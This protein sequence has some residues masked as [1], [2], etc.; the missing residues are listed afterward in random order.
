[1]NSKIFLMSSA[2][3]FQEELLSPFSRAMADEGGG[4]RPERQ[5]RVGSTGRG[6][7]RVPESRGGRAAMLGP[8][9]GGDF[10][11]RQSFLFGSFLFHSRRRCSRS[12]P[13][14]SFCWSRAQT[15]CRRR[16]PAPLPPLPASLSATFLPP[17][18][19][20]LRPP[21]SLPSR[22]SSSSS[23]PLGLPALRVRPGRLSAS[24]AAAF[25]DVLLPGAPCPQCGGAAFG[26]PAPLPA[27]AR[28][29]EP[30][31]G[32]CGGRGQVWSVGRSGGT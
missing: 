30:G 26:R 28:A 10:G 16:S 27:A 32:R 24:R 31:E 7:R 19:P 2:C 14:F 22:S 1:M 9:A 5:G 29:L 6:R 13:S 3:F 17:Q 25:G 18:L 8:G 21:S 4:Q 12:L 11:L 20:P 23:P 15:S